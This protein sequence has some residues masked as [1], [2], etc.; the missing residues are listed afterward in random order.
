VGPLNAATATRRAIVV[1]TLATM[2]LGLS[3]CGATRSASLTDPAATPSSTTPS[4]TTPSSTT[5]SSTAGSIPST[6]T[7]P[8]CATSQ[9]RLTFLSSVGASG[10]ATSEFRFTNAGGSAC[11]LY[12]YPGY[13]PLGAQGQP[14]PEDL[15][16]TVTPGSDLNGIRS[17]GTVPYEG[18]PSTV[19]LAPGSAADFEVVFTDHP[20]LTVENHSVHV[21][22]ECFVA[23][24]VRVWPPNQTVP[25]K[26]S[27]ANP[28]DKLAG[29]YC[30]VL[31]QQTPIIDIG[32]VFSASK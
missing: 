18:P 6:A 25:L 8:E 9:L 28:A 1:V 5:P 30:G 14:L 4:S 2:S 16:R 20:L 7:T 26:V 31:S 19:R 3:A 11:R 23:F 32:Y 21:N 27:V 29:E 15:V 24:S 12:G 17:S 22:S 10:V 13:Q